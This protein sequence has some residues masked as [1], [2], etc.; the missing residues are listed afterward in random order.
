M[1]RLTKNGYTDEFEIK[2]T[3]S[4]FH[5]DFKKSQR[6]KFRWNTERKAWDDDPPRVKHDI[7]KGSEGGPNRFWFVI[8]EALHPLITVPD[9]AGL[10]VA[11]KYSATPVKPAPKRHKE[12]WTG[13]RIGILETFYHRFWNHEISTQ[14]PV[15]QS[16]EPPAT[17]AFAL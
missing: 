5:A 17:E 10:M 2:L 16:M 8:P 7:L 9:Y 11:G 3:V 15:E 6:G 4:D 13:G 12:K 1:W 14:R